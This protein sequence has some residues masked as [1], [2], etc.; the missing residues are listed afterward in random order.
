MIDK[1]K[2]KILIDHCEMFLHG[3]S[4][5]LFHFF[6][7]EKPE[8]AEKYNNFCLINLVAVMFLIA[9]KGETEK[10]NDAGGV[11]YRLL[12]PF[13][14]NY[15]LNPIEKL[16]NTS[17]GETTFGDYQ[18]RMRN[19]LCVHGDF[20]RDSLP[21]AEKNVIYFEKNL[22]KFNSLFGELIYEVDVLK[23]ELEKLI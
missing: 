16:M 17:I 8:I 23:K 13:N 5:D 1:E 9:D 15:L 18:R 21:L 2:I 4:F 22:E 6:Y 11:F 19:N 14:Y 10:D 7:S 12:K 20:S 3:T